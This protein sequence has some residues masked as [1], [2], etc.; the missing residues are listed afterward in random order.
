MDIFVIF[1]DYLVLIFNEFAN[2]PKLLAVDL[3]RVFV[4]KSSVEI[5]IHLWSHSSFFPS[6]FSKQMLR[7]M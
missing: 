3:M 1:K 6:L 2:F 5:F 7:T 4:F